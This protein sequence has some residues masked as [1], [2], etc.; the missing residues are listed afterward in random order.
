[1][2]F[3]QAAMSVAFLAALTAQAK[4]KTLNL[5]PTS[6]HVTSQAT[7]E[8]NHESNSKDDRGFKSCGAQDLLDSKSGPPPVAS[9]DGRPPKLGPFSFPLLGN[10]CVNS[11]GTK[12]AESSA[13]E[14]C[15][16]NNIE[17]QRP[18]TFRSY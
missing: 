13:R 3:I 8:G 18:P 4:P 5:A 6:W 16:R 12:V 17:T 10:G 7:I 11:T 2:K 14:G 9:G 1:M 15:A